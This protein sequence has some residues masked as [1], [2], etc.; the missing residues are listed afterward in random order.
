MGIL[1]MDDLQNFLLTKFESRLVESIEKNEL[2]WDETVTLSL[3]HLRTKLFFDKASWHYK[4]TR[5]V[6]IHLG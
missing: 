4:L 2:K 5:P 3:R 6:G 1:S